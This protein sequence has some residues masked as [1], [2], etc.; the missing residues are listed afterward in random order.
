MIMEKN[1]FTK[2]YMWVFIGLMLTFG[3]GLMLATSESLINLV[4]GTGLYWVVFIAEFIIAIILPVRLMKMS[5]NTAI[6]LYLLYTILTGLTFASIFLL[7][8]IASIIFIFLVAALCFLIFAMFGRFTNIDLSK[9]GIILLM[10]LVGVLILEII[11]IFLANGTLDTTL[12]IIGLIIFFAYIAYDIQKI[13]R[14]E[15]YGMDPDKLAIYGA[16]DLFLDF[17]NVFIRLLQLFGKRR[18]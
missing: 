2:V 14:L 5:K 16:F 11:N 9:I 4:F 3:S 1:I 17:I 8:E 13:K 10:A 7:Y 12:C 18:D 6:V 15:A